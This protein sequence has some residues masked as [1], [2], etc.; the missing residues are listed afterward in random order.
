MPR[1]TQPD[2]AEAI[3]L[4]QLDNED[5]AALEQIARQMGPPHGAATLSD[6][7]KVRLWGQLDPRVDPDLLPTRLM[8]EGLPPEEAQELAV[9]Q[10]YPHLLDLYT[11][12]TRDAE[13]AD[14]LTRVAERPYV[15]SMLEGIDDPEERAKEAERMERLYNRDVEEK[16]A[17]FLARRQSMPAPTMQTPGQPSMPEEGAPS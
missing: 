16:R 7:E 10:E 8:L 17:A 12:P 13:L 5:S 11:Q 2:S 3:A 1:Q 9:L 14:M 4:Q 15:L 6:K